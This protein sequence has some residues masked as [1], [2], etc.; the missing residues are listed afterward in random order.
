[1]MPVIFRV[2]GLG[3][4]IP[5]Y[6]LALMIGF[7][8]SIMWAARRA[9][10]SGAN[11]DVV[12]NCGFLAL[13]GGIV[14]SRAMY[15]VHYWEQFAVYGSP[16]R[17]AW[18]IV[19]GLTRGGLEVYG[20]F[21]AVVIL[22]LGYL[23][24]WKHSIRWYLDIMAPSAALGM[25]IGRIGCFLNGCCFG[26]VC[27]LPWAVTFPYGSGPALQQWGDRLPEAGLPDELLVFSEGALSPSGAAVA[28]L[29][30]E[31]LTLPPEKLDE[32]QA[33][34]AEYD[35]RL[36]ELG[37]KLRATSE[38]DETLRLRQEVRKV[39]QERQRA[40]LAARGGMSCQPP[41]AVIVNQMRARDMSAGELRALAKQH[42]SLPVHPAQLYS[43]I[44]LLLLAGLLSALYWRRT[45]DGQV[46]CVLLLVEPLTRWML[47]V[48]RADN[49]VDTLG[50]FTIS[51]FLAV[52][53][54]LVGLI[55]LIGLKWA[56]P[57]S[58]RARIWEPPEEDGGKVQGSSGSA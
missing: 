9:V 10:R 1:M 58:P 23:F 30:R 21:I 41:P 45:R 43:T 6:G 53:L 24:F 44:T 35:E 51:Q 7:L 34:V 36:E 50:T 5:G 57:R 46:I 56:T 33:A 40:M 11:P 39:Q 13:L 17:I 54:S 38:A 3:W 4:E 2:P 31:V 8:L 22:V 12:L 14:G 26:G 19:F 37:R 27:D 49:P 55:G 25:G 18:E 15:V 47:E 42:S 28:P 16:G 29:P 52:M 32:I 20:G 48:I